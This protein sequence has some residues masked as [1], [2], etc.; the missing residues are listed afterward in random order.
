[1]PYLIVDAV[2]FAARKL[3]KSEL[4]E[5]QASFRELSRFARSLDNEQLTQSGIPLRYKKILN[6]M[7]TV[8][9]EIFSFSQFRKSKTILTLTLIVRQGAPHRRG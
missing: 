5:N 1:M 4:A 9:R 7:S 6:E 2:R 3:G 8:S